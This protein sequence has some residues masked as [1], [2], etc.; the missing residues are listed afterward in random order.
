MPKPKYD[1]KPARRV[2]LLA[3]EETLE[4]IK[5]RG[6]KAATVAAEL[7]KIYDY[8][9]AET[10]A[11]FRALAKARG[12]EPAELIARAAEGALAIRI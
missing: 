8:M 5:L 6:E 9:S 7:L 2:G 12:C 4:N 1:G 10:L 11:R 3:A